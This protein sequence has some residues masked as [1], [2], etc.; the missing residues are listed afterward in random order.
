MTADLHSLF[1][2]FSNPDSSG[3]TQTTSGWS[4]DHK[5]PGHSATA[6]SARPLTESA[7]RRS[8]AADILPAD[9]AHV[10]VTP[11]LNDLGGHGGSDA[12]V[13]A[14][15]A[16]V[17]SQLSCSE[18]A[19]IV[20][21]IAS[22]FRNSRVSLSWH[23]RG[24]QRLPRPIATTRP[25]PAD[26]AGRRA[27][28][29][30]AAKDNYLD[31][32]LSAP[33]VPRPLSRVVLPLAIA[34]CVLAS[35]GGSGSSPNTSASVS[36]STAAGS[37]HTAPVESSSVASERVLV[38]GDVVNTA[39]LQSGIRDFLKLS[40]EERR[41]VLSTLSGRFERQLWTLTGLEKE[42]GGPAP[43]DSAFAASSASLL[44][45]VTAM[46]VPQLQAMGSSTADTSTTIASTGAPAE[47][48]VAPAAFT[49]TDGSGV[50]LAGF[51]R[52]QA[53]ATPNIGMGLFAGLVTVLLGA[54]GAVTASNDAKEGAPPESGSIGAA[55]QAGSEA[56]LTASLSKALFD[57][58]YK[59]TEGGVDTNFRTSLVIGPCPDPEGKFQATAVVDTAASKG[60]VGQTLKLEVTVS[61]RTNDEAEVAEVDVT[62]RTQIADFSGGKG[63][64]V[65][66]TVGIPNDGRATATFNRSGG[67]VTDTFVGDAIR[68][69]SLFEV[70]ARDALVKGA[71]K[72]W[73]SGRCVRLQP[74]ASP[75]PKGMKPSST[76]TITAAPRSKIDGGQVGGTVTATLA[77]GT[78]S[79]TPSDGKIPADATFVYTAS[80][81]KDQTGTVSL[82][83]RSKR[84]VAKA[85][86]D[87]DTKQTAAYRV[88][89]G[90]QKFVV[91]EVICDIMV[92]FV[93]HG[94][95]LNISFTGGLA[96]SYKYSVGG[97]ATG[98]GA[99]TIDLPG[100]A[101]S[102]GT[103]NGI[104][105]GSTKSSMG[106]FKE[107]GAIPFT[108]TPAS[109]T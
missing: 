104:G 93:L 47:T 56:K 37:G 64:F 103:L 44:A 6:Q 61:G 99:Y 89:G 14:F 41:Q 31:R 19:Q 90:K 18:S 40:T 20:R 100:G 98:G 65:D 27:H 39:M 45:A 70:V 62:A 17:L 51:V 38:K 13:R 9:V 69:A 5:Q 49:P 26:E 97:M 25:P 76:S 43:T 57:A 81:E 30:K 15:L 2:W 95:G 67:T 53:G 35:C 48:V 4:P 32:M 21:R 68:V 105:G 78:T 46:K 85:S 102:P 34:M 106:G 66:L 42:L 33:S 60:R 75:G 87:F 36:I 82:T 7:L 50:E 59:G 55:G 72:G 10:V 73:E 12:T 107:A 88:V 29:W 23:R 92:P 77:S 86:V 80:P 24:R 74:A 11:L 109:C 79:V 83:A 54:E 1:D 84:G 16:K 58:A 94:G 3:D 28:R 108:M 71:Q 8:A 63:Q 101:G 91:D 22:G 52:T 96:G